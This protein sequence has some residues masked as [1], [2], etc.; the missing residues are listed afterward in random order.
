MNK[1][2]EIQEFLKALAGAIDE[3]IQERFGKMGFAFIL[4]EFNE[5][6]ISNYISN[7]DRSDMIKTLRETAD[8]LEKNQDVPPANTTIQ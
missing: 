7:A 2:I 4:F 3:E 6:G 8:R 1:Q 5:P